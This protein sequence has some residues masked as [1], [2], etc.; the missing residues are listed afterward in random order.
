MAKKLPHGISTDIKQVAA[1]IPS[2]PRR[3]PNGEPIKASRIVRGMQFRAGELDADKNPIKQDS[4]YIIPATKFELVN[5]TKRLKQA[6]IK[7]GEQ[8]IKDYIVLAGVEYRAWVEY[9]IQMGHIKTQVAASNSTEQPK[10][11]TSK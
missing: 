10:E 9:G 2:Y 5:H 11:D 4:K 1:S 3:L 6:Y 7:N 8:G